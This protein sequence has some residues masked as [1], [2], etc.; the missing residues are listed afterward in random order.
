MTLLKLSIQMLGIL[1]VLDMIDG[2]LQGRNSV[3]VVDFYTQN[4]NQNTSIFYMEAQ[5]SGMNI[6][7]VTL[8]QVYI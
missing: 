8:D 4:K 1:Q 2:M 7:Q 3:V 5:D 6:R